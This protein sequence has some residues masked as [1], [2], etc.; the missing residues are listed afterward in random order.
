M[1]CAQRV[2]L[3][4]LRAESHADTLQGLDATTVWRGEEMRGVVSND[5]LHG[6]IVGSVRG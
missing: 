5:G 2:A 1:H 4:V 3:V 6:R